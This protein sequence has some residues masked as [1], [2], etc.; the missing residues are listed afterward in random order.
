MRATEP[1]EA[2]D[3][4]ARR[5]QSLRKAQRGGPPQAAALKTRAGECSCPTRFWGWLPGSLRT[6]RKTLTCHETTLPNM[7]S[8]LHSLQTRW[9][10]NHCRPRSKPPELSSQ[11][12]VNTAGSAS[13]RHHAASVLVP[14][15]PAFFPLLSQPAGVLRGWTAQRPWVPWKQVLPVLLSL[16]PSTHTVQVA[17]SVL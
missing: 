13:P 6:P 1:R 2:A 4:A 5:G 3:F 9:F 7:F 10:A 14:A 8:Q 15:L 12:P 11:S 16:A 17:N